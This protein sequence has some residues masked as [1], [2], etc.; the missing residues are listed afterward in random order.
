MYFL[1]F[2]FIMREIPAPFMLIER[3]E[4]GFIKVPGSL[5]AEANHTVM[6]LK[7]EEMIDECNENINESKFY[8]NMRSEMNC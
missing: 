4:N 8:A 6:I 3:G 5:I 7:Q 1:S 2:L